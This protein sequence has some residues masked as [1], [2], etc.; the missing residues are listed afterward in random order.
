[1]R[2]IILFKGDY[3]F[4]SN[5]YYHSKNETIEHLY[6]AAKTTNSKEVK[7]ILNAST[8]MKAKKIGRQVKLRSNW[9]KIKVE[10]MHA[11][12]YQKKFNKYNRLKRLLIAT[13]TVYLEEGNHWHDNFWGNCYCQKCKNILGQ[14]TL[15][16]ILMDIRNKIMK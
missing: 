16:I 12:I 2:K 11:L 15:G 1:M 13:R 8:P 3:L 6:Q 4:L 7:R 14:N 9:E 10:T 5:F